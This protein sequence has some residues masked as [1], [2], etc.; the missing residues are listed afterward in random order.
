LTTP[1]AG[2][3]NQLVLHFGAALGFKNNLKNQFKML[4]RENEKDYI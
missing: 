3:K 1:R 2:C 4:D